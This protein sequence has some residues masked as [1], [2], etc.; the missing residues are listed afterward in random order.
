[1]R[2]F[3]LWNANCLKIDQVCTFSP[4]HDSSEPANLRPATCGS[5]V[6]K[7]KCYLLG[8]L[9]DSGTHWGFCPLEGDRKAFC[10]RWDISEDTV[11]QRM[12]ALLHFGYL[13]A[14]IL[15]WSLFCIVQGNFVLWEVAHWS[16][17]G[18]KN[19]TN[20]RHDTSQPPET[21]VDLCLHPLCLLVLVTLLYQLPLCPLLVCV[22][23]P[24]K[25]VATFSQTMLPMLCQQAFRKPNLL[26]KVLTQNVGPG[27]ITLLSPDLSCLWGCDWGCIFVVV[28]VYLLFLKV[29]CTFKE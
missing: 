27:N 3:P 26:C 10:S 8:Y 11:A 23:F 25:P 2:V 14:G 6:S 16:C 29:N 12:G 28:D 17:G 4:T 15:T 5:L 19:L 20:Q 22:A 13:R 24:S 21:I 18:E 1:M 7:A 9:W